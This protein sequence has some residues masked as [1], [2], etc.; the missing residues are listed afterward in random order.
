MLT[1]ALVIDVLLHKLLD[2]FNFVLSLFMLSLIQ[3]DLVVFISQL[4]PLHVISLINFL[5]RHV[6]R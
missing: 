3:C 5:N 4:I 6:F 1:N 2:L